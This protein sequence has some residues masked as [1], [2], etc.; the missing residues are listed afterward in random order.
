LRPGLAAG[1]EK[2]RDPQRLAKI[3]AA[4]R[5]Q[6]R[7]REVVEVLRAANRARKHTEATRRTMSTTHRQ[8]GT[9]PPKTGRPWTVAEDELVRRL[10]AAA[11]AGWSLAAVYLRRRQLVPQPG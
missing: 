5:G 2:A 11:R 8:L 7:P 9:R 4:K 10:S 3:A 1:R 6:P